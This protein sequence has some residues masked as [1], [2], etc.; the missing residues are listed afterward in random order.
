MKTYDAVAD[1]FDVV[2]KWDGGGIQGV[3]LEMG[4]KD[5]ALE[6]A[7]WIREYGMDTEPQAIKRLALN[8]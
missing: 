3:A 2:I 6:A 7:Q 1:G 8:L 4:S 5:R